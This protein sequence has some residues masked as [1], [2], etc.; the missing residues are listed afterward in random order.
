MS[1]GFTIQIV[2]IYMTLSLHVPVLAFQVSLRQ[3]LRL[4]KL[5]KNLTHCV[6]QSYSIHVKLMTVSLAFVARWQS[7]FS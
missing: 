5:K 3:V 2:L 4:H 7:E 6:T 1:Q